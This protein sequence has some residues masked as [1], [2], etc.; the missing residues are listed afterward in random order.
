LALAVTAALIAVP[1][2][3][4]HANPPPNPSDGQISNAQRQKAALADLVGQLG[5]EVAQMQTE[6]QQLA[7]A[8]ELAEQ[9]LAYALAQLAQA[10]AASEVA[11]Q[12]VAAAQSR[13][14]GA[15]NRFRSYVQ[16]TYM[17][18]EIGGTTGT[19]LTADDPN[20]VLQESA[21]Q[22]Y[23]S[24]H[25]LDAIGT[26]QTATVAKSN[27]DAKAR[28]A[29]QR[30]KD[31]TA[32]AA[33]ANQDA[34]DAVLSAQARK[35]QLDATMAADQVALQQAQSQL[36]TLNHQRAA[37]LAYQAEQARL[38]AEALA[39][40]LA[41]EAQARAAAERQR[42]AEA[43]AAAQNNQGGGGSTFVANAPAPSPSGGGWTSARG[44]QAVNRAEAYLGWMYA[45][46]GGD[47]S[48]PTYGVCA[49]DGA[50]N[51]CHIRGFDC[52]GLTLYGWAP[53]IGLAHYAASQ[54]WQAGSLHPGLSD[55]APGDLLF[56]SS[57]GTVAGIHHV[58]MYVGGGSVIQA[59]QSGSLIQ[60]TAVSDVSW[61]YY[62][63]T[64]PLT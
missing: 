46:A 25:Q 24:D 18:G 56:W 20:V 27:A 57:N 29:V 39:R 30:N 49:A 7:A 14:V 34:A 62:G 8:Q 11:A 33:Q 60:I 42:A 12:A 36:A 44:Q 63:A 13:V 16:A 5:A 50:F 32:A 6:L 10:R 47:A 51:D 38:R 61:G 4:A 19:L 64:R 48:G 26:L 17:S 9:K 55:L 40:K 35:R 59:P 53:Y 52:S 54:Y 45:W 15:E 1:G 23:E 37:Y 31:A 21:L 22:T 3:T 43:A 41:A 28:L 58:A 2:R